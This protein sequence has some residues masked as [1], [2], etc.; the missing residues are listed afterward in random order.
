M[1][2]TDFHPAEEYDDPVA[3]ATDW[4]CLTSG[5]TN[6]HAYRI[7]RIS[8]LLYMC[9]PSW[10]NIAFQSS[11]ILMGLA[12]ILSGVY[13]QVYQVSN[14]PLPA[15]ITIFALGV[16]F[17]GVGSLM[18]GYMLQTTRFDKSNNQLRSSRRAWLK[19]LRLSQEPEVIPLEDIYALQLLIFNGDLDGSSYTGHELNAILKT[20]ERVSLFSTG[21]DPEIQVE[22]AELAEFLEV[23]VWVANS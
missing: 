9:K 13:I 22:I 18:G 2:R 14:V 7:K 21:A 19:R 10:S 1:K 6:L 3:A 16:I 4:T 11:F 17:L 15:L 8:P 12:G 5:S 20:A 23:P